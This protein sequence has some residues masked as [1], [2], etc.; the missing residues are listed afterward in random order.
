MNIPT[1]QILQNLGI[2]RLSP[3]Q[4]EMQKLGETPHH[5]VLLSPTGSGKTLSYLLP[6]LRHIDESSPTLQAVVV[7]PSRELAAQSL[8]VFDAMKTKVRAMALYGGRSAMEEH[9]KMN[10][11][12][13]VV[14]FA[15]PGRLIDHLDK[16]NLNA[17]HV[18]LIVIDEFDKCLEAGFEEQ[19]QEV[20]SRMPQRAKRW[21]LSATDSIKIPNFVSIGNA[22]R[23]DFRTPEEH[24]FRIQTYIVDSPVKDKLEA[25]ARLL[26]S[27][28]SKKSIVFVSHRESA[29]RVGAFLRKVGFAIQIYH[30]GLEQDI[31][32]RNLFKYRCGAA[33]V[34]VSTDLAARGL[35]IPQ[36]EAV[37]HYHL[38]ADK[39]INA[40]RE[41]RTARWDAE[42]AA[43]YIVGPEEQCP[44]FVEQPIPYSIEQ[45]VAPHPAIPPMAA[46]YIGRGKKDKLSKGDIV[47]LLCQRGGLRSEQIGTIE[48]H[49]RHSYVAIPH[50]LLRKTL[51]GIRGERIKKMR[52]IIEEMRE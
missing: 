42:G 15:T 36:V 11:N 25:L 52:T 27:M 29:E 9:R 12:S 47:G 48:V 4:E 28:E 44:E 22:Q 41:G 7:T 40:H 51:T 26:S 23:I 14:V 43:F 46:L 17:E 6:L 37:I 21:L 34:L 16:G 45:C 49:P 32:E 33:N 20:V 10:P 35:D 50:Q 13:P 24:N 19:M 39:T 1:N 31:R 38:P 30:G 8:S 2:D 3:M 5:I 18:R